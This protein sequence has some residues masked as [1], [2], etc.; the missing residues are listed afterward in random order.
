MGKQIIV[1]ILKA[2]FLLLGYLFSH[3]K[4]IVLIV[5]AGFV[6]GI[7]FNLTKSPDTPD[8][9][10]YQRTAPPVIEA[11]KVVQTYSRIYYVRSMTETDTILWLDEYYT[12]DYVNGKLQW[13]FYDK[14][15]PMPHDRIFQI[16]D[17]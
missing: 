17:R 11:N 7:Y 9:P 5:I 2:P 1:L 6:A 12:H 10:D 16:Y 13:V 14:P 15:N 8:I 4:L 3:P